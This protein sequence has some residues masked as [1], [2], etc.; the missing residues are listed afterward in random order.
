MTTPTPTTPYLRLAAMAD[1][2]GYQIH[3]TFRHRTC[4][5]ILK[6]LKGVAQAGVSIPYIGFESSCLELIDALR[7]GL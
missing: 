7:G 4:T 2:L 5:I 1:E 6:D 3:H